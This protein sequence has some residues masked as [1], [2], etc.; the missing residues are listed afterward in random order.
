MTSYILTSLGKYSASQ[1]TICLIVTNFGQSLAFLNSKT[2]PSLND[3][4]Q[5]SVPS[6]KHCLA[7]TNV[8]G[9]N[10]SLSVISVR[11]IQLL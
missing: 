7:D 2:K 1:S 8:S 9:K 10:A 3:S 11:G 5:A 6:W 4:G